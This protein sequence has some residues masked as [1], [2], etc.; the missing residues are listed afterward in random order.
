VKVGG[1]LFDLSD[2]GPRLRRWLDAHAPRQ[3]I[4]VPGGGPTADAVCALDRT[5]NLG[6][7]TAHWLAL[8]ALSLNARL[9]RALLGKRAAVA[10]S[11]AQCRR[12]WAANQWPILDPW[13][14]CRTDAALPSSWDVTSDAIAGR[15]AV[16]VGAGELVLLKSAPPPG[17]A[18]A[19]AECGYVDAW[20]PR[21]LAGSGVRVRAVNLRAL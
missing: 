5:H 4:L 21:I 9:L 10:L 19:W 8:R 12:R 11:V 15:V 16:V 14:F 1:S 3:T 13:A 7:D 20:L 6:D 18:A 17:D 2:L